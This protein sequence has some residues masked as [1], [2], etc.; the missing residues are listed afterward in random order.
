MGLGCLYPHLAQKV[1]G[2]FALAKWFFIGINP[3]E[4]ENLVAREV[5]TIISFYKV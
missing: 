4:P 2:S 3:V 1:Y 5:M